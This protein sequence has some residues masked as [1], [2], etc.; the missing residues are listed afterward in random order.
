ML[1][2]ATSLF[3][4]ADPI[5]FIGEGSSGTIADY[6]ARLFANLGLFVIESLARRLVR[7]RSGT[8]LPD[9]SR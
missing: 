1:G 3:E 5:I 4:R 7:L 6:G 9:R 8:D 2:E